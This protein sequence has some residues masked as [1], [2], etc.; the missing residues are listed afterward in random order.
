MRS[1][2][3]IEDE[4][5]VEVSFRRIFQWF[6]FVFPPDF[7]CFVP[8]VDPQLSGFVCLPA[9][10]GLGRHMGSYGLGDSTYPAAHGGCTLVH[11]KLSIRQ[12]FVGE[13]SAV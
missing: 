3:R 13:K 5:R 6:L 4:G 2:S 12:S 7:F 10:L 11:A 1:S 9:W 8:V